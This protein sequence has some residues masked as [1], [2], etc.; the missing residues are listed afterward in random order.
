MKTNFWISK[1]E[2]L[3]TNAKSTRET[4]EIEQRMGALV[5]SF[6][7]GRGFNEEFDAYLEKNPVKKE[8]VEWRRKKY[9]LK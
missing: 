7:I 5:A 1:F 8:F 2:T 6:I 9:N 4:E 3:L